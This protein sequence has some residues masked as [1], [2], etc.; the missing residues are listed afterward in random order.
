M[1]L[2]GLAAAKRA[3]HADEVRTFLVVP[4]GLEPLLGTFRRIPNGRA[5]LARPFRRDAAAASI[6]DTLCG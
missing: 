2:V 5:V 6:L 4:T 3:K 1:A